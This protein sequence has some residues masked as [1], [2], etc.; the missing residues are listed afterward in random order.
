[1]VL[2]GIIISGIFCLIEPAIIYNGNQ[3]LISHI[4]LTILI[5]IM[6]WEGNLRIDMWLNKKLPWEEKTILRI[7]VQS[8]SN[9]L[10]TVGVIYFSVIIYA[11]YLNCFPLDGR[12]EK[13]IISIVIGVLV[14]FLI[15]SI[16]IGT[17][18][19]RQWKSSLI[20][21][22]KYKKENL[23]AQFENLKN[24]INPHFLFNS[25]SVLSSLVY[26][27]SDKAVTFINQL[28]KV[29]RYLL[30]YKDK[31]L[32]ELKEEM[33][34]IHSY[35]YL[36][37]IRYEDNIDFQIQIPNEKLSF[38]IPPLAL[39]ILLENTIKHNIIS[40]AQPLKVVIGTDDNYLIVKN[41]LQLRIHDEQTSKMGLKNI[42]ER[43]SYF[44]DRKV[45]IDDSKNNFTVKIPLLE[46]KI[47]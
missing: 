18:F 45:L 4:L 11:H 32:V 41:N 29:Y 16:E 38:K 20:E 37:K 23:Q 46:I 14:S 26:K 42:S 24:Q 43:Y 40:S 22:E 1:M 12:N 28:S 9:L 27:D 8:I 25:L 6:V 31:E 19:F 5:T 21:I 35:C 2:V 30:D 47:R 13:L 3:N 39:Q 10:Y 36:L 44:T 17:L 7:V 33:D 34:F 15:F